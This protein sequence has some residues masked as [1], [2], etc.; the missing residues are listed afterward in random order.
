MKA[1]LCKAFGP[2][3]DLVVE[4]IPSPKAKKGQVVIQIKACGVNFPDLLITQGLYQF[5]PPLPFSPG[6]EVSGIVKEVGE[7]VTHLQE[8]DRVFT[9]LMFGGFA[10]EVAADAKAVFKIPDE[11]DF[12]N[13]ASLM[14][15][16][17]TSYHALV[18]RAKLQAG[19]TLL[20]LGAAG[21]VGLAALDIAKALG[22][23]VIAAASTDEKLAFC[24]QF[25]A[26]EIV[27]YS[28]DDLK[29]SVKKLTKG[30]G[31]NVIYDPVGGA[32]SEQ[33]FRAI[34]WEGRFLVVGFAAGDIPK[35]PLNLPLLKGADI[36]GVFWGAFT[37][38]S[39]KQNLENLQAILKLFQEGK[40]RNH[41]HATYPLEKV[42]EAL[43]EVAERKVQGKVVLT[44][45]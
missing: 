37:M 14:M 10:E 19:E 23:K 32:F 41:I 40:L 31:A 24:K 33:A 12:V 29:E 7:G 27:N 34:A 30:Q 25:G 38:R 1:V 13:A 11:M 26:D 15:T 22:A 45:D 2:W 18:D 36:V 20:I 17:G 16:Y 5:K 42:A 6:A 43:Q 28:K 21:G 44:T 8:G 9:G 4:E 35:I 39:P 3:S